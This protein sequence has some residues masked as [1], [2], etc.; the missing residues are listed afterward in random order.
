MKEEKLKALEN[1]THDKPVVQVQSELNWI[2]QSG[3][4]TFDQRKE[5]L[6]GEDLNAPSFRQLNYLTAVVTSYDAKG[7][8]RVCQGVALRVLC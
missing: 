2:M 3:G 6:N 5:V 7:Y 1:E 4:T 8:K